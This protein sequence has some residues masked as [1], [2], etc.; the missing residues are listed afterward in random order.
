MERGALGNAAE[1]QRQRAAIEDQVRRY[2]EAGG[3][4]TV[5]SAP[6][7]VPGKAVHTDS[8]S[9]TEDIGDAPDL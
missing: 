4:I 2:L 7:G 5:L 8:W 1:K 6:V 9:G 3:S